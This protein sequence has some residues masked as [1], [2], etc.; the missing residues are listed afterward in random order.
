MRETS[1]LHHSG[2]PLAVGLRNS[3]RKRLPGKIG[4]HRPSWAALKFGD[5]RVA[6]SSKRVHLDNAGSEEAGYFSSFP[7]YRYRGAFDEGCEFGWV[8]GNPI[9]RYEIFRCRKGTFTSVPEKSR[10]Y[11]NLQGTKSSGRESHD[12]DKLLEKSLR[13]EISQLAGIVG[14]TL[15]SFVAGD[16]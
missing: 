11:F 2:S 14:I 1:V 16:W 15:I 10:V 6:G 9:T 4:N 13:K 5:G 8:K 3:S 12:R 7:R